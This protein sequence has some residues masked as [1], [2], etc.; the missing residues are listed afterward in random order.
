MT[1]WLLKI[2]IGLFVTI[3]NAAACHCL[4]QVVFLL[5]LPPSVSLYFCG[6]GRVDLY[7]NG[8]AT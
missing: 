5:N 8:K 4:V 2:V 6:V 7:D 3:I 1:G